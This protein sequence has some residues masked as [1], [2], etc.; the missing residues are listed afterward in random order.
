MKTPGNVEPTAPGWYM[1]QYEEFNTIEARY[2]DER[3]W[4]IVPGVESFFGERNGDFWWDNCSP[5]KNIP[6]WAMSIYDR[7]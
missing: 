6:D 5:G 2:Y 7:S 3:G 4:Q 1:V